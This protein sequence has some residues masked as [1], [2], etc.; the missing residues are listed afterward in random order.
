MIADLSEKYDEVKAEIAKATPNMNVCYGKNETIK[1]KEK[2][3]DEDDSSTQD[4]LKD[5]DN[6]LAFFVKKILKFKV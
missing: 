1:G 4:E 2:I 3:E 6:H 5:L